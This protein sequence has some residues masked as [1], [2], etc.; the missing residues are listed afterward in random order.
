MNNN[1]DSEHV[2]EN[3][4]KSN[5]SN[6]EKASTADIMAVIGNIDKD[7]EDCRPNEAIAVD[8][9]TTL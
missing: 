7:A 6:E 1:I 8:D 4:T 5:S 2:Q 9:E 3:S